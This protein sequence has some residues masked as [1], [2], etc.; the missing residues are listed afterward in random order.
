MKR[1]LL[2]LTNL[3]RKAQAPCLAPKSVGSLDEKTLLV[4]AGEGETLEGLGAESRQ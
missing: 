2:Q 3:L 1:T 4:F